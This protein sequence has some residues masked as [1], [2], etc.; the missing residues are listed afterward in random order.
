[1]KRMFALIGAVSLSACGGTS[2]STVIE[3]PAA[4]SLLTDFAKPMIVETAPAPIAAPSGDMPDIVADSGG[5]DVNFASLLNNLRIS[6]GTT[7]VAFDARLNEAAQ[8]HAQDMVDRG[9]FAHDTP[10]GLNPGDRIIAAGYNPRR[11]GENIAQGQQSEQAAL[12]GW[13]NSPPHNELLGADGFEDFALGVAGTGSKLSWVLVM[14]T[15]R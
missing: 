14:A 13:I 3:V 7:P 15:E 2:V 5:E 1:M 8:L 10:E 4:P 12:T 6:R 11:W 9:Y